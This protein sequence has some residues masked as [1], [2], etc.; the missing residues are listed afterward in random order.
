MI[1][2][3]MTPLAII[4]VAQAENVMELVDCQAAII[5]EKVKGHAPLLIKTLIHAVTFWR[6]SSI[7]FTPTQMPFGI[8]T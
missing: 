8:G 2:L 4:M 3:V 7:W 5:T 1:A 6:I